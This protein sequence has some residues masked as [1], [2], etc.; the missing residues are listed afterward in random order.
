MVTSG[1]ATRLHTRSEAPDANFDVD[2]G[3]G[4]RARTGRSPVHL[5]PAG[6]AILGGLLVASAAV[7]LFTVAIGAG[8]PESSYAVASRPLPAGTKLG[9]GDVV[10]EPLAL[11]D[12]LRSRS[13]D[14]ATKLIGATLVAPLAQGE[15]VQASVVAAGGNTSNRREISFSVDAGEL[16]RSLQ[17]NQRVDVIATYGTGSDAV[18]AVAVPSAQVVALSDSSSVVAGGDTVVTV[19]LDTEN[20]ALALAHALALGRI[21]VVLTSAGPPAIATPPAYRTPT[22]ATSNTAG[23]SPGFTR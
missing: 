6:R 20:D 1:V 5:P 18:T 21:T 3:P 8:V 14:T 7:G 15:L 19:G 11:P 13:F 12:R 10:L 2:P 16:T 9:P 23:S 17:P 4:R 22:G